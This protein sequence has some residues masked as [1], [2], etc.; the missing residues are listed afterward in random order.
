MTCFSTAKKNIQGI[1]KWGN[2][3]TEI[4]SLSVMFHRS[5]ITMW[6]HFNPQ[7]QNFVDN[8][9]VPSSV[10]GLLYMR[11]YWKTVSHNYP[12]DSGKC[13][14]IPRVK[15]GQYPIFTPWYMLFMGWRWFAKKILIMSRKSTKLPSKNII[16]RIYLVS[17][18]VVHARSVLC[19][20]GVEFDRTSR[21]FTKI[22]HLW[23]TYIIANLFS[24]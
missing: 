16:F 4:T 18:A 9:C 13:W 5:F 1:V 12:N 22:I 24:K 6:H 15:L 3:G 21:N 10:Y 17:E 19:K 20:K 11:N 23:I 8:F 14:N 2:D 7:M